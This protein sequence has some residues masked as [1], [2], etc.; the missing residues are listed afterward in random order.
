MIEFNEKE[1]E[2]VAREYCRITDRDPDE[3]VGHAIEGSGAWHMSPQW[4]L[5][6]VKVRE[7]LTMDAAMWE[8]QA[9]RD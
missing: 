3:R 4:M 5:V 9:Q 7:R 1:V 2:R 8:A 6:A